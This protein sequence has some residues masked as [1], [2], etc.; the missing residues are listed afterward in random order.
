M[1]LA[2]TL[3]KEPRKYRVYDS[4]YNTGTRY[5]YQIKITT[6]VWTGSTKVQG[7]VIDKIGHKSVKV[8]VGKET[9]D[10]WKIVCSF[11]VL[12]ARLTM[13]KAE[14]GQQGQICEHTDGSIFENDHI[15]SS[16]FATPCVFCISLILSKC[17]LLPC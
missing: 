17:L 15:L 16:G 14:L 3:D 12:L 9:M 1:K 7:F 8:R 6:F 4:I 11:L 5:W 13:T 2:R 10:T